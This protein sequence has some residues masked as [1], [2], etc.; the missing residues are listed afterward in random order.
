MAAMAS[1]VKLGAPA[2]RELASGALDCPTIGTHG[3]LISVGILAA[4]F[5][6]LAVRRGICR[7]DPEIFS[8]QMAI[9]VEHTPRL[10]PARGM[11]RIDDAFKNIS[12]PDFWAGCIFNDGN[13]TRRDRLWMFHQS[14]PCF[15]AERTD[16]LCERRV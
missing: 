6:I 15:L 10:E 3:R 9:M 7:L 11:Q 2:R 12:V 13:I 14:I 4:F 5:C 8:D 16:T 1:K